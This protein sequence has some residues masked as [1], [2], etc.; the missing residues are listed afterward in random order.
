MLKFNRVY[1]DPID[2]PDPD[3]NPIGDDEDGYED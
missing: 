1:N 2:P 3:V